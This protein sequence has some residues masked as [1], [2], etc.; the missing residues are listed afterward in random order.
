MSTLTSRPSGGLPASPRPARRRSQWRRAAAWS[1]G[2]N[3][4]LAAW[5]WAIAVVGVTVALVI[6]DRVATV[7]M[8]IMQFASQGATW[9]PFAV[10]ITFVTSQIGVHVANGMTRRAFIRAHLLSVVVSAAAYTLLMSTAMAVEGAVYD[11][12]GWPHVPG[13]VE[14]ALWQDAFA[15]SLL[16]YGLVFL[17]AQ[18]SGLLV[19]IAY[20][21]FGGWWGTLLLPLTVAPVV[22]VQIAGPVLG[23]TWNGREISEPLGTGVPVS[24]WGFLAGALVLIAL[25]ALAFSRLARDVPVRRVAA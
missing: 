22:L 17:A 4:Y 15:P 8:S 9:F 6:I 11:R 1:L 21:R 20:Y 5:F 16:E 3:L 13:D 10:A 18:M 2:A 12:L 7:E 24:A 19:G 25:A 23:G 14:R